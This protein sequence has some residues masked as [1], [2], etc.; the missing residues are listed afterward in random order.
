MSWTQSE[1]QRKP[2]GGCKPPPGPI[3]KA[4]DRFDLGRYPKPTRFGRITIP[5]GAS[6]RIK[7]GANWRSHTMRR[8]L[9]FKTT[10]P[11][12]RDW[13]FFVHEGWLIAARPDDCEVA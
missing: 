2:Q 3:G 1:S 10:R 13:W 4:G 6:V 7:R 12:G 5:N 11:D 8:S 9:T